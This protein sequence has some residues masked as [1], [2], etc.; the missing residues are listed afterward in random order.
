MS[1]RRYRISHRTIYSYD[2]DV[3]DSLGIA[4]L[5]PRELPWQRVLATELTLQPTP[6]DR[7]DDLDYYGN[8]ATY[9]QVTEPHQVLE[10]ARAYDDHPNDTA[11]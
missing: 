11:M 8:T 1:S 6:A 4:Y 9:F 3:T 7:T 5:V 10:F 2:E